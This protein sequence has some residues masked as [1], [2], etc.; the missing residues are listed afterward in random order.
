MRQSPPITITENDVRGNDATAAGSPL[1]YAAAIFNGTLPTY[2]QAALLVAGSYSVTSRACDLLVNSLGI[3]GRHVHMIPLSM[4]PY[5]N[6]ADIIIDYMPDPIALAKKKSWV[7]FK[8]KMD[9]VDVDFELSPD[10]AYVEEIKTQWA[11][12]KMHIKRQA[13]MGFVQNL[14]VGTKIE[15]IFSF[16][17]ETSTK[18]ESSIKNKLKLALSGDTRIPGT[19]KSINVEFYGAGGF[20]LK[21]GTVKPVFEGGVMFTVP[22]D[23]F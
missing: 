9:Q 11:P 1:P 10:G 3:P 19:K 2:P 4:L 5:Q 15:S 12:L 23:L 8:V 16:D 20:K 14:K 13:T 18:V 6:R 17:R 22:F 21:D 7:E